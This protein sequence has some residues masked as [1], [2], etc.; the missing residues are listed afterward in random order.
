[1]DRLYP[2]IL[3]YCNAGCK[4]V[5]EVQ[6]HGGASGNPEFTQTGSGGDDRLGRDFNPDYSVLGKRSGSHSVTDELGYG[7]Y[8]CR[9]YRSAAE[10]RDESNLGN[11]PGRSS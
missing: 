10:V 7:A 6:E 11:D 8:I 9:L 3:H 4:A 1:N 5:S 2:S